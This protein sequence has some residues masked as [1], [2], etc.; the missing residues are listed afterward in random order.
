MTSFIST[1]LPFLGWS[2]LTIVLSILISQWIGKRYPEFKFWNR[3]ILHVICVFTCALLIGHINSNLFLGGL[4]LLMAAVLFLELQFKFLKVNHDNSLGVPLFPLAF[5][6]LLLFGL[7]H[8][9]VAISGIVLAISDALGGAIGYTFGRY[10]FYPFK[11]KKSIT[12][13]VAFF[14]ITI[15]VL[16]IQPYVSLDSQPILILSVLGTAAEMFSWRGSDNFS[17]IYILSLGLHF[18]IQ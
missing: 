13:S 7:N 5:G 3:K 18:F 14:L 4:F 1:Y 17:I 2:V 6:S 10:H 16:N 12:G 15:I 11:E 8:E 9:L